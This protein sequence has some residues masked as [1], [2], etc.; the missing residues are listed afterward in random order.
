MAPKKAA[1]V[2]KRSTRQDPD[3]VQVAVR[4][5]ADWP[6]RL[7]ALAEALSLP[8]L[9]LTPTD[10]FRMALARGMALLEADAE[11]RRSLV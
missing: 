3:S 8:G 2:A 7:A 10:A 4:I 5:P 9:A 6:P 1:K 11:G